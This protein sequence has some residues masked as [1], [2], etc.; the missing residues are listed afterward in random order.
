MDGTDM[1]LELFRHE[2]L[3]GYP[4]QA[5]I[6]KISCTLWDYGNFVC[7]FEQAAA[8]AFDDG[9][10]AWAAFDVP[11]K[12][13]WRSNG[14]GGWP[15]CHG[16]RYLYGVLENSGIYHSGTYAGGSVG[17]V[18]DGCEKKGEKIRISFCAVYAGGVCYALSGTD[19]GGIEKMRAV[20]RRCKWTKGSLTIETALW[21]PVILL[22]WMGTVS[23]CLFVHNRAWATAA[24]YEAA[25]TGSWDA[26]RQKGDVEERAR[27]RLQVLL[28]QPLHGAR[29]LQ[30]A[31][32]K[33]GG[34]LMVSIESRQDAYG[35]MQ[36]EFHVEGSRK[37]CRPVS[38]IRKAES[39]QNA[40]GQSGGS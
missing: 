12:G 36:W 32:E 25:V 5:D 16:F 11:G 33:K 14:A 28:R 26:I 38:F 17:R 31:V 40:A 13:K 15:D 37:L 2:Q 8:G 23:V 34:T 27:E 21:M 1:Y 35:G 7:L 29:D 18:F 3:S 22:V 39:L 9:G 24:A 20:E 10:G 30:T 19:R 6:F 4:A